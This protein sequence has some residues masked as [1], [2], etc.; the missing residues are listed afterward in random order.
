[1]NAMAWNLDG[2]AAP[3]GGNV[4][5]HSTPVPEM[6]FSPRGSQ[7]ASHHLPFTLIHPGSVV[8]ADAVVGGAGVVVS[9]V[10]EA[11]RTDDG[12]D[13]GANTDQASE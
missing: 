8:G 12:V 4:D 13:E 10:I 11:G 3:V 6:R 2:V 7:A 5:M 1:M 9:I